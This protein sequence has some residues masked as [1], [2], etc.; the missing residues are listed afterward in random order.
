M[1]YNRSFHAAVCVLLA[2]GAFY[3]AAKN[4]SVSYFPFIFFWARSTTSMAFERVGIIRGRYRYRVPSSWPSRYLLA[5]QVSGPRIVALVCLLPSECP[6]FL[7]ACLTLL[8]L[9]DP[10]IPFMRIIRLL[11]ARIPCNIMIFIHKSVIL[12]FY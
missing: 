1:I 2:T 12:Y 10:P 5:L 4:V 6:L 8:I 11:Q 3:E 9:L 7:S